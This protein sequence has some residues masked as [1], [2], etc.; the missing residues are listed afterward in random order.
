[1]TSHD[2]YILRL[3]PMQ[4]LESALVNRVQ[5]QTFEVA[6]AVYMVCM[7]VHDVSMYGSWGLCR[8]PPEN[9]EHH[10]QYTPP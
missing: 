9:P 7:Y 6:Q 3:Y 10:P 2:P 8:A 5:S 1:M 4:D